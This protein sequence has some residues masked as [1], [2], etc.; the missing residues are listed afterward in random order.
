MLVHFLIIFSTCCGASFQSK[1]FYFLN[2]LDESGKVE[3]SWVD[4]KII[5][6]QQKCQVQVVVIQLFTVFPKLNH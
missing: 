2:C 4:A 1:L 6:D 3:M 5:Q